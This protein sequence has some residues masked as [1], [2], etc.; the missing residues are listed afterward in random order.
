MWI[1]IIFILNLEPRYAG[2][3]N[4]VETDQESS[5]IQAVYKYIQI[6]GDSINF[7]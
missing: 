1:M 6:T 5:L 4:T 7:G 2:H 3:K